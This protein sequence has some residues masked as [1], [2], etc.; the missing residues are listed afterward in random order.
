MLFYL[1]GLV[2]VYLVLHSQK[3]IQ[4]KILFNSHYYHHHHHHHHH[5]Y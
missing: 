5:H 1:L 2:F 4:K 3:K